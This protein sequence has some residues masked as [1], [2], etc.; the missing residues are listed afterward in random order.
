M[1]IFDFWKN[2]TNDKYGISLDIGT[3][4]V[5][6]LVFE[7]KDDKV[8]ILGVGRERQK[9]TDMQAGT[10]TDINGVIDNCAKALKAAEEMAGVQ[11]NQAVV[12][13]AG[14]LVKGKTTTVH[15]K[16]SQAKSKIN[17]AELKL[18]VDK[19][20]ERAF[21]RAREALA[22]ETG[23][24]E[25]D[26]KLVNAAV[27]DVRIDGQ[28]VSN[29]LGFQGKDVSIGIFNAFAPIV[30]LGAVQT[31]VEEL[32]LNL[33][34]IAAEPY[35]VAKAVAL[36]DSQEFSAIFIDIGGGTTDVAVVR[37]GGLEGTKMFGFGG[38][39]FTKRLSDV[40]NVSFNNA[41]EIKLSYAKNILDDKSYRLVNEALDSDCKVWLAGVELSL[42]EFISS[43]A[44]ADAGNEPFPSKVLLCGGGSALPDIKKVL[45]EDKWYERMPFI[46]K[47]EVNFI[48]TTDVG[49][50][51]DKTKE[52]KNPQDI[53][54]MALADLALDFTTEKGALEGILSKV[55]SSMKE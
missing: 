4:F 34:T 9:L 5:K 8:E 41:E 46:R 55:I 32:N 23:H 35:A 36:E 1:G 10:V 54:P 3:E 27:V 12:G 26:V 49:R 53:T 40:L 44:S 42:G 43:T 24:D 7:I 45:L 33:L 13:I 38:R 28:R 11:A 51:V 31:I 22:E 19:V 47:P 16:R 21:S 15:Y 20:Q 48:Q 37:N 30:Q 52:L 18:I 39:T 2:Q 14:E 50:V 25:I 6:V 17:H 29:P